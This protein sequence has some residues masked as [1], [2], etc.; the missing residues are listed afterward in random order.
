MYSTVWCSSH[1][2]RECLRNHFGSR[3]PGAHTDF[4]ILLPSCNTRSRP[5]S[6]QSFVD[7]AGGPHCVWCMCALVHLVWMSNACAPHRCVPSHTSVWRLVC[8]CVWISENT[9]PRHSILVVLLL[10]FRTTFFMEWNIAG[11]FYGLDHH[12]HTHGAS[13]MYI[14]ISMHTISFPYE[15]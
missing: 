15:T 4:S 2:E 9:L 1:G 6:I 12:S 5:V 13:Y 10:L 11:I 3:L 7:V 14:P 8:V